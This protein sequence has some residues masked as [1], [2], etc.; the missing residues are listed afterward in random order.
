VDRTDDLSRLSVSFDDYIRRSAAPFPAARWNFLSLSLTLVVLASIG[1]LAYQTTRPLVQRNVDAVR[2]IACGPATGDV[3]PRRTGLAKVTV[4]LVKG[5]TL[6]SVFTDAGASSADAA[7]AVAAIA[8]VYNIR[9]LRIGQMIELSFE[10]PASG[11]ADAGTLRAVAFSPSAERTITAARN[12]Q[13]EFRAKDVSVPLV[14]RTFHQGGTIDGSL[15]TVAIRAGIPDET[16]VELIR[17]FSYKVDLQRD[18]RAGDSFEVYY[19][20]FFTGDGTPVRKGNI[21]YAALRLGNRVISLYRFQNGK[22]VGYFDAHGESAQS[23]LMRTPVDG[24]RITSRFGMRFH[25]VLGF[26]RMHKGIDFGVPAGTPV[27]AAGNGVVVSAGWHGG[28]GNFV[29]IRHADGISTGYGHLSRFAANIRPGTHVSQ[30]SIIAY[31]GSTGLST[32]P[33]LH[34]EISVNNHQINPLRMIV[35]GTTKLQGRALELFRAAKAEIDAMLA[36]TALQATPRQAAG[37]TNRRG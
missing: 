9:K 15:Y 5:D 14:A 21:A 17:L 2:C 35:T 24:A 32:G 10:R 8:D 23:S 27:M 16:V 18:M 13:G 20:Y 33:H 25:P 36:R 37:D 7:A 31:S 28:Y 11:S 4:G 1:Q 6:S 26:S 29:L 30:G 3:R 12:G 19:D 34:Y 22:N